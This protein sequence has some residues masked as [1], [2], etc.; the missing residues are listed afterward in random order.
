MVL[1]L[2]GLR[3]CHSDVSQS[4]G[5]PLGWQYQEFYTVPSEKVSLH[6]RMFAKIRGT[7]LGVP[8][9]GITAFWG[10]VRVFIETNNSLHMKFKLV[11]CRISTIRNPQKWTPQN[12]AITTEPVGF[13]APP[14]PPNFEKSTCIGRVRGGFVS[15]P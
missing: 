1:R 13:E 7:I 4:G 10:G 15:I 5:E 2:E 14:P 12:A 9:P 3:F 8:I 6:V 11:T